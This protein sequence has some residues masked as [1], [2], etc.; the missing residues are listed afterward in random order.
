MNFIEHK[1]SAV[2]PVIGILLML[3]VTIIIA[4]VVSGFAGGFAGD[5]SKAPQ[6]SIVA[7]DIVVNEAYD[8]SNTDYDFNV[9]AGKAADIYVVFEHQGGDGIN[10]NNVEIY[11]GCTKYPSAK[12]VISNGKTPESSD[13]FFGDHT[14]IQSTFSKGWTKYLETFPEKGSISS[15]GSKF[16]LHADYARWRISGDSSAPWK[17]ISWKPSGA[18]GAFSVDV[19][20]YLTY[21][22]I[23]KATKK[24][25]ASGQIP[26]KDFT[27]SLT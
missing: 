17:K 3:V 14:N 9:V 10:L 16:V 5:T 24:S 11:L 25:I 1:D 19:G 13:S 18:A 26:V 6:A 22:I 27:V 21:D 4:A 2:S 20:D 8:G 15:P 23:D 12:S 7:K